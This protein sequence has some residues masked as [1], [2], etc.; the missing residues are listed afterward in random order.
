MAIHLTVVDIFP[1]GL[2]RRVTEDFAYL[3]EGRKSLFC[4]SLNFSQIFQL[5]NKTNIEWLQINEYL[6]PSES[7]AAKH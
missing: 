7:E 2:R 5:Q 6:H 3:H 4:H 1:F